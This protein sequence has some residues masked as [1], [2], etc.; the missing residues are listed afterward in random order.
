[1]AKPSSRPRTP[2]A[3]HCCGESGRASGPPPILFPLLFSRIYLLQAALGGQ[4]YVGFF[5]GCEERGLLFITGCG[6]LSVVAF[7]AVCKGFTALCCN[8][9]SQLLWGLWDLPIP[10]VEPVSPTLLGR[11]FITEPRG[12]PYPIS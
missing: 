6:L 12:K 1:M 7:L 5:P 9:Q 3:S 11:F 8:A 4:C 10:G 2:L